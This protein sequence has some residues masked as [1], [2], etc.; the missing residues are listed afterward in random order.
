MAYCLCGTGLCSHLH[1]VSYCKRVLLRVAVED[2]VLSY[3]YVLLRSIH[4]N[5]IIYWILFCITRRQTHKKAKKYLQIQRLGRNNIPAY[6]GQGHLEFTLQVFTTHD[7]SG[8]SHLS[9]T[10]FQPAENA[11][12][13][14]FVNVGHF[15]VVERWLASSVVTTLY[16]EEKTKT[17]QISANDF[18]LAH[19]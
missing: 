4:Q 5:E 8:L 6:L 13:A 15:A 12:Q 18:P 10:F 2:C 11:D 16:G 14:A 7:L 9:Q 1:I 17:Y 19:S 3:Y